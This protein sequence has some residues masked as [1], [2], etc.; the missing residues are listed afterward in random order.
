MCFF[1]LRGAIKQHTRTHLCENRRHHW[2]GPFSWRSLFQVLVRALGSTFEGP[3]SS[4]FQ[5][6]CFLHKPIGLIKQQSDHTVDGRNQ[7]RTSWIWSICSTAA[8][9]EMFHQAFD[10]HWGWD[11]T[12]YGFLVMVGFLL[13]SLMGWFSQSKEETGHT[14]I[15]WDTLDA[16]SW[17]PVYVRRK[18]ATSICDSG[19][20]PKKNAT[21]TAYSSLGLLLGFFLA[22]PRPR[23]CCNWQ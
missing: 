13:A 16:S 14:H 19:V 4:T 18:Q 23:F 6:Q 17:M 1:F 8:S 20:G 7:F 12:L 5:P 10:S 15:Q 9:L 11:G 2:V 22:C 21:T 3:T